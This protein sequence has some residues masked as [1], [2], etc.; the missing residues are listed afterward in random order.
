VEH[1][2]QD[3]GNLNIKLGEIFMKKI[4][5][6]IGTTLILSVL[7]ACG[8]SGGSGGETSNVAPTNTFAISSTTYANNGIIPVAAACTGQGGNNISPQITLSDLP[9]TTNK[10]ALIMD[11]EVAPCGTGRNACVHWAVFNLPASKTQI[12][13]G[14]NLLSDTNVK[15]G[16]TYDD[17]STGYQGPCPP[18][19]HTYKLTAYALKDTMPNITSINFQSNNTRAAFEEN[20]ATHIIDKVTLTGR[21]PQ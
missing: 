18:T 3:C 16:K 20:F 8:G 10:I 17:N 2:H 11:D 19:N 15:Y 9:S 12:S 5:Y 21:Y 6:S 14:E 13:A 4:M 1:S 7:A